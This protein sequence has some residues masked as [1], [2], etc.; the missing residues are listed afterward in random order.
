MRTLTDSFKSKNAHLFL[1]HHNAFDVNKS[2]SR[3]YFQ[4]FFLA[5]IIQLT[6]KNAFLPGHMKSDPKS[7]VLVGSGPLWRIMFPVYQEK[8][9][10]MLNYEPESKLSEATLIWD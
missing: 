9:I 7:T 10:L 2:P 1:Q 8:K 4:K 6:I 5:N 3:Y